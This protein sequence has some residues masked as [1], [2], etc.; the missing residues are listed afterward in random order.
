MIKS[1]RGEDRKNF[2]NSYADKPG[3]RMSLLSTPPIYTISDE[4]LY[5]I[6]ERNNIEDDDRDRI[7]Y[8]IH[9]ERERVIRELAHSEMQVVIP[10]IS[11]DK[12]NESPVFLSLSGLF[13]EKDIFYTYEEYCRHM[14]LAKQFEK[15]H[16]GYSLVL[17][18]NMTFRNIQIFVNKGKWVMISKNKTP[19]IHF[20]VTHSG[21]RMNLEKMTEMMAM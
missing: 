6:L 5:S 9:E 17:K 2:L 8:Y 18:K 11:I 4:L 7:V 14:D 12:Y 21:I 16:Q 13:Y 3:V 1:D 10:E 19:A 15:D 20:I